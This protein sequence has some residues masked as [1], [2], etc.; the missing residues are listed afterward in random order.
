V[1][2]TLLTTVAAAIASAI[3]PAADGA[4][5]ADRDYLAFCVR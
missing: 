3:A 5:C 1:R 4:I 2:R